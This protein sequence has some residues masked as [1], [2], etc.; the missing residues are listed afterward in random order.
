MENFGICDEREIEEVL[1][2]LLGVWEV[3]KVKEFFRDLFFFWSDVYG[4]VV[5]CVGFRR[6]GDV[7]WGK[8]SGVVGLG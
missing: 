7:V 3:M 4:K 2:F 5:K 1:L 6:K 8:K